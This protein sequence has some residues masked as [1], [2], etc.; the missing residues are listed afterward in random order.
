MSELSKELLDEITDRLVAGLHPEKIIL[1]GSHAWG[2]PN[3]ASDLDLYVI[4]PTSDLRPT[5]RATN[6]LR[7]LRGIRAPFDVLVR[8]RAESDSMGSVYASL[9]RQVLERGRVLFG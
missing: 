1:F 5:Q 6:A 8:T 7:L 9:D 2:E 4:V 3:E